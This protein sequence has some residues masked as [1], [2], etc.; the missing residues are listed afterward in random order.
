VRIGDS[1]PL[2]TGV[3]LDHNGHTVP[4]GT[5]VRFIMSYADS[6]IT[7]QVEALTA[8]GVARAT[9]RVESAGT[10]LIRAESEPAKTSD[11]LTFI[12]PPE[13]ATITAPTPTPTATQTPTSTPTEKPTATPQ[14]PTPTP[15]PTPSLPP[16]Q[17]DFGDWF[18]ALLAALAIGS[19]NMGVAWLWRQLRWGLRGG[20]MAF[21]GG[22]LAYCYLALELPGSQAW[23]EQQG[24]AGVILLTVGG[25]IFGMGIAWSWRWMQ[26]TLS[27]R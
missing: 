11:I 9:L 4:D 7:Q 1:L 26:Q 2:R 24:T 3:I 14:P 6:P 23:L 19:A 21:I 20:L 15:T 13:N 12:V 16:A 5:T 18:A 22:L 27:T 8:N 10:L 25:A 17:A